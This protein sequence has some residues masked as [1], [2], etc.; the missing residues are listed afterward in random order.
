MRAA[1]A[2]AALAI[3]F[4]TSPSSLGIGGE[5]IPSPIY[6][7][8][9]DGHRT[10]LTHSAS[11]IEEAVISPDGRRVAYVG[12]SYRG[13]RIYVAATD[14]HGVSRWSSSLGADTSFDGQIAWSPDGRRLAVV[15]G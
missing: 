14:G 8:W 10:V 12:N 6:R 9:L 3:F 5:P 11:D 4:L 2:F 13:G 15:A 1:I 7:L